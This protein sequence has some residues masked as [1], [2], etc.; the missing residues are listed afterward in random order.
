[1]PCCYSVHFSGRHKS[2]MHEKHLKR[3]KEF[4]FRNY[5]QSYSASALAG[6][7]HWRV[8]STF[9]LLPSGRSL[10]TAAAAL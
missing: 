5:H 6:L 10:A 1:M 2:K 4:Q 3:S 7:L 8:L 9:S